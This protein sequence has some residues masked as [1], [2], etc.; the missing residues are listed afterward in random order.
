MS[1]HRFRTLL[2]ALVVLALVGCGG[3]RPVANDEVA[4]AADLAIRLATG[5]RSDAD[6][7]RDAGRRPAA[8]LTFLGIEEGM[9]VMDVLASDGYYTE[10]LAE[11]V[12]P[13][14]RVYA[15]NTPI[16]L[17]MGGGVYDEAMTARLAD[18]RLPNVVRLDADFEA[19]ELA[20]GSLDAAVAALD[21]HDLFD[22]GEDA[23][24]AVLL[25]LRETLEPGGLLGVIDHAGAPGQDEL[26]TRLRRIDEA[27]AVASL[28]RAGFEIE[29]TRDLLRNPDDDRSG[30]AFAPD[31]RDTTD[32]FVIRAR[33]PDE[34]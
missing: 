27:R 20:A 18:G 32:R 6:K 33:K 13:E 22:G 16:L 3:A 34:E 26:N 10:V 2:T 11:A 30:N 17:Q 15:H 28:E 4:R 29:A 1:A 5:A 25:V 21:L 8:V 19:L 14:G 23:A 7:A 24:H 9:Q 31:R 12:G